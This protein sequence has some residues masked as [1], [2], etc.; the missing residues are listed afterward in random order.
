MV[1]S[2]RGETWVREIMSDAESDTDTD[3]E[4]TVAGRQKG[5][6]PKQS[7][8]DIRNSELDTRPFHTRHKYKIGRGANLSGWLKGSSRS[9]VTVNVN[10]AVERYR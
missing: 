3:P 9:A 8:P 7:T 10:V 4:L 2:Y 6:V 1:R 5:G